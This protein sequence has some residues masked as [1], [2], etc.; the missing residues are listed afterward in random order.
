M[1]RTKNRIY[2]IML[3]DKGSIY[4]LVVANGHEYSPTSKIDENGKFAGWVNGKALTGWIK[5]VENGVPKLT[6]IPCK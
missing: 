1:G 6:K 4:S 5:G 3:D 2:Q